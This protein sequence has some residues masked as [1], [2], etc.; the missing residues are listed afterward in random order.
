MSYDRE[1]WS[2]ALLDYCTARYHSESNDFTSQIVRLMKMEA[3]ARRV[4]DSLGPLQVPFHVVLEALAEADS[5]KLGGADQMV[6]EKW[7]HAPFLLKV[8][9]DEQ[10]Q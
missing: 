10:F 9:T 7:K 4:R 8:R 2:V 5:G 6:E 3:E 1:A